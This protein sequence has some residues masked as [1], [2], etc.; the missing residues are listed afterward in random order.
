MIMIPRAIDM[1]TP[2]CTNRTYQGLIEEF[3][4]IESQE[5]SVPLEIIQP[6]QEESKNQ[7]DSKNGT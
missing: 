1:A 5:F 3:F 2:F 6:N 7:N 4:P